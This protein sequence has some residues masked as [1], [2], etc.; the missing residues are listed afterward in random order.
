MPSSSTP[1]RS[2]A[3]SLVLIIV[4][5]I[6]AVLIAVLLI[7]KNSS[8]NGGGANEV[9]I[10][11]IPKGTTHEY[12]RS[13]HAGAVKAQRELAEK[14]QHLKI[15]WK[16]PLRED[17]RT[18]QIDVVN[19]FIGQNIG[20]IVLAPLDNVA[21]VAPVEMAVGQ[22][23]PVVIIDSSLQSDKPQSYIATNNRDGGRQAAKRLGDILGGTGKVVM[24]RYAQG[25]ASTEEREKGFLE[26]MQAYPK[27]EL[28]ST[29]QHGG[30]TQETALTASLNLLSRVK[31]TV[32]G[33]FTPNETTTA[34]MLLAMR[35]LGINGK[36]KLVG[37]DSNDL[38]IGGIKANDIQG[39]VV[40]DPFQMG[41]LGV[42]NIAAVLQGKTVPKVV[43]TP[44]KL[45]TPD[46]LT[47]PDIAALVNPPL[48]KYLDESGAQ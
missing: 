5:A 11:V 12:W 23:I 47:D 1:A 19:N 14:G 7:R 42:M 32:T 24:L 2:G 15:I 21:L 33:I 28:I 17:D 37:F 18:T 25:S 31:D 36:V 20:G 27:I 35:Q 26:G 40:Q 8:A 34:G 3:A 46:N 38:L 6:L 29:D 4:A 45:V 16:G 22:G 43:D 13:I 10:A 48:A 39:L 41:Y 30:A 44:V 9:S